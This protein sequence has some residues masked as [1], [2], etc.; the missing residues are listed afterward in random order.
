MASRTLNPAFF[1]VALGL[2]TGCAP[3]APAEAPV[4]PV[5]HAWPDPEPPLQ[6]SAADLR[7]AE[8]AELTGMELGR[9]WT[10]QDP[11]Y[12]WW[13]DAYDFSPSDQWL[14]HVRLA[15]VRFGDVCSASFVSPEGL[16]M[17]NH[18]CARACIEELSSPAADLLEDGFYA[19]GRAQ[20]LEC[21]GLFLDQLRSMEDVTSRVLAAAEGLA[22]DTARARAQA[23]AAEALEEAC[24][25]ETG[26][27]CQVVSLYHG[28]RYHVYRYHRFEPVR[29]VFAPEHQAAS[30]GGDPDNF[31]YPRYALDVAF[32][33][34]YDAEGHPVRG[35]P[36][37]SWSS[38]GA[39]EGELVFVVGSPGATSRLLT[40]AQL[41]YE[42]H[43]THPYIVQY[44]TDVVDLYRW[45]A[46][47]GPDAERSVR[48]ELYNMEN[49]LKAYTGQLAGLQ[50]TLLV[51]RKIQWEAGL[52]RAVLAD[53]DL[54][55]RYGDVWDRL[56]AI[57]LAKL[58]LGL[59]VAIYNIG[60]I[61]DP[62]IGLAGQLV[63]WVRESGLPPEERHED[64]GAETLA[65]IEQRLLDPAPFNPEIAARLLAIRLR[66][67]RSFLPSDDALVRT[68]F[69]PGETAMEAAE[70]L[71]RE[72]RIM[73]PDFRRRLMEGGP[74]AI[75]AEDDLSVRLALTMDRA[76]RE[77]AP[78]LEE[79][80]AVES[81]QEERLANTLFA[82][83]GTAIPPDATFTPRITDGVMAR[84][85]FNGTI[86]PPRTS[87]HGVFERAANFGDE[88]PFTLPPRYA[89]ARGRVDMTAPLNFVTTNDITGGNSGSPM[90]NR[91]GEIVGVVFDSNIEALPNEWLFR[92]EAGRAVGVHSA[93]IIEAL[94]SI[95]QAE[96]L[97]REL[98]GR[99]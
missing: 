19:P 87:F 23:E 20:E 56:E 95:Y 53:P 7:A 77:L 27:T 69:R 81:V 31:T 2:A 49:A 88:M 1:L 9:M 66:L 58:P 92:E 48:E 59:R 13:R 44:L 57:Q 30:F 25:A 86:A 70:R 41:M 40:V 61:G 72:S 60:F 11:P 45:I 37:F 8:R 68:A 74:A 65:E 24:E 14:E 71:V 82:V 73:D 89:A 62:H 80:E 67:A 85:P 75:A 4:P 6:P 12:R 35:E 54:R 94:R 18:H 32:L 55:S 5:A 39:E 42:K 90:L 43:R 84:Y 51:G 26:L 28:G 98:L 78:R 29:L 47:F 33:R 99:P 3:T 15:S 17:T 52:R 91:D 38:S 64:Y 63:R 50:D 10:F 93:G 34:A 97:I 36:H 22:A 79:L 21:R 96:A 16:V 76:Q 46:G 83:E